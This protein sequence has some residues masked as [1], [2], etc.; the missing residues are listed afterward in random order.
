[1]ERNQVRRRMAVSSFIVAL[2]TGIGSIALG[3]V[4]DELA[5]RVVSMVGIIV[6]YIGGLLG[7]VG[8][9]WRLGSQENRARMDAGPSLPSGPDDGN[10]PG[11]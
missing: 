2:V 3:L 6:P 5:A 11:E 4:S 1:M 9:Y 10:L 8:W 7:I